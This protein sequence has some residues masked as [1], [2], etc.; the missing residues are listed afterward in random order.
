[1]IGCSAG[2]TRVLSNPPSE[3]K[4]A[5]RGSRGIHSKDHHLSAK[6]SIS[7]RLQSLIMASISLTLSPS[8]LLY[9]QFRLP[10]FICHFFP[11]LTSCFLSVCCYGSFYRV[12]V[13]PFLVLISFEC[14]T[15]LSLALL[16]LSLSFSVSSHPLLL[17]FVFSILPGLCLISVCASFWEKEQSRG[18][19]TKTGESDVQLLNPTNTFRP[20]LTPNTCS[21]HVSLFLSSLLFFH[22][23]P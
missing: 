2:G 12:G 17:S 21:E 10:V 20:R 7:P 23:L 16:P 14:A 6:A 22:C 18:G 13:Y 19:M 4:A 15:C 8:I 1:M 11:F 3:M 5:R 9:P